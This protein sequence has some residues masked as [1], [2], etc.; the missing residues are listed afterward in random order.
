MKCEKCE[1]Q[2]LDVDDVFRHSGKELCEDCY[3]NIMSPPKACDPWAVYMAKSTI[4]NDT[5]VLTNKQN[6]ILAV[7]RETGGIEPEALAAR[8]ELTLI[9]LERELATLRHMEKIK[10]NLRDG[11]KI[12][13]L[14]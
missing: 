1:K 7:L 2:I 5:A 8:V 4:A 3:I 13:L 12:I 9:D 14:W 11:I 6:D 10:A